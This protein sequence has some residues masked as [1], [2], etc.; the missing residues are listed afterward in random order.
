MGV[1]LY[2][3]CMFI[4]RKPNASGS[5]SV[6]V[7][8]KT[9]L[10]QQKVVRTIGVA[11]GAAE[12]EALERRARDFIEESQGP[13]LPGM[14]DDSSSIH[15]FL[16]SI[17]NGQ[18]Q[19]I[20][21]E[22]VF[23]KLYDEIG[24]GALDNELFRHLVVCRLFNPGS[25]LK[26][27]DYLDRYL[28]VHYTPSRIYRFLDDLCL[29]QSSGSG[30]AAPD[31][32]E[33]VERISYLHTL[34]VVGGA[35]CVCFYDMTTL[36]F[37]SSEEDE[38]RRYGFSKDGKNACPQIFLGL[39][40]AAGGNPIGYEIFE[41]NTSESRTLIPMIRKLSD[42]FDFGKPVVIADSGLLTKNNIS[43]LERDGYQY[44]L[45]ARPKNETV[46]IRNQI[47][48][49]K[50]SDGDL[51]EI[52]KGAGVRL[53]VSMS[54]K[55]AHNDAHNRQRGLARLQKNLGSGK[56][57]KQNINNRGYNK[58]LVMKGK[59]EIA[60]DMEKFNADAQWDGIKGY[61]TNTS[62]S[63]EEIIGNYG[64]L[65]LIERAFRLNKGDL[66]ARPIY[67]RLRNRIEGHICVCFTAYTILL[68]LDRRLAKAKSRLTVYRAQELTKNMYALTCVLPNWNTPKRF[69]FKMTKEQQELI[70]AVNLDGG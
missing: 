9:K 18:I 28:H 45:G 63:K 4:R 69:V 5:I 53:I 3:L 8:E 49:M 46:A 19:V 12:V 54:T 29:R 11:R 62:L 41:G 64:N 17:G 48:Q 32:K 50:L 36:Y 44:I 33:Q 56:L 67:H 2:F 60:I 66:A 37:E 57:T 21:P 47:L 51:A 61:I 22:L 39:L 1:P 10:R 26:T 7:V 59:V 42:R 38:L 24:Y 20:G 35:I 70:N 58:Y 65:W 6:Q 25:K 15:A 30:K 27:I 13:F 31:I 43:E 40:V 16:E 68:E 14:F 55:R 34:K 52:D 23:G